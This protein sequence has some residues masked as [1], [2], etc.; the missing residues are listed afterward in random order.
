MDKISAAVNTVGAFSVLT[1]FGCD[2]DVLVSG[3]LELLTHAAFNI[4]RNA[5]QF[6]VEDNNIHMQLAATSSQVYL[7]IADKGYGILPENVDYILQP[8]M[9]LNPYGEESLPGVGL[10]LALAGK[11]LHRHKGFLTIE[12]KQGQYTKVTMVLPRSKKNVSGQKT[13][14]S[15]LLIDKFSPLYVHLHYYCRRLP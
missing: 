9:S 4:I 10:G 1:Q 6:S 13:D 15:D 3:D 5:V 11:V 12:T 14:G 7:S 2:S 8:H